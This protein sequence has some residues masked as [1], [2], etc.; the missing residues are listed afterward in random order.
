MVGGGTT[1]ARSER[2]AEGKSLDGKAGRSGCAVPT[3]NTI[4]PPCCAAINRATKWGIDTWY[5]TP[6]RGQIC[7]IRAALWQKNLF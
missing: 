2:R 5:Q 3:A 7:E 1:R 4:S 6:N